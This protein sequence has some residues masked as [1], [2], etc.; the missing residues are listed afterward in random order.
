MI[1]LSISIVNTSNWSYLQ[2][3]L[4]A[5]REATSGISYEVLVVDNVSTDGSI[6]KTRA[7]FPWVV[8]SVNDARHGFA[9]NNNI[10]LRRSSGRYLMLLNDDTLVQPDALRNAVE[11]LDAHADVGAVGCRMINPDGTIQV[12]SARRLP[13]PLR[14]L[15]REVGVTRLLSRL[16]LLRPEVISADDHDTV[17]DIDLPQE[18]GMIVRREVVDRVGILDERFFMF[19]EGADWCRRIKSAG[20]TIRFLPQ[21]P[22][23]HFGDVTNKRTN[24]RMFIQHYKSTY[25]YFQKESRASAGF[26]RL[27]MIAA[28]AM[29]YVASYARQLVARKVDQEEVRRCYRAL[30][31]LLVFRIGDPDYPFPT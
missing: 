4:D 28:V 13:T 17:R 2:P 5:I 25:L 23:V 9:F 8:L 7:Q 22:I 31:D 19:G 1:D 27:L 18:A 11:Y 12:T 30:L 3:C 15:W 14:A 26:Y 24:V 6:E 10:N 16:K 21:C 20:W 29:K